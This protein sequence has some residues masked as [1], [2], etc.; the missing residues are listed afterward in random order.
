[1]RWA[2]LNRLLGTKNRFHQPG[3]LTQMV[4]TWRWRV[5]RATTRFLGVKQ[6]ESFVSQSGY[7][8]GLVLFLISVLTLTG[9]LASAAFVNAAPPAAV[10]ISASFSFNQRGLGIRRDGKLSSEA[11]SN[12]KTQLR[13]FRDV[14]TIEG[15]NRSWAA[16]IHV[17]RQQ[18]SLDGGLVMKTIPGPIPSQYWF[19]CRARGN[20]LLAWRAGGVDRACSEGLKLM[21]RWRQ[22]KSLDSSAK[23][24]VLIA[25]AEEEEFTISPTSQATLLRTEDNGSG[26]IIKTLA[27][28]FRVV[29]ANFPQGQTI[30]KGQQYAYPQDQV[31]PFNADAALQSPEVQDFLKDQNWANPNIPKPL[32]NAIKSQ[33]QS[34]RSPGLSGASKP[35]EVDSRVLKATIYLNSPETILRLAYS[36][37]PQDFSSF[38]RSN[39][40]AIVASGTFAFGKDWQMISEGRPLAGTFRFSTGT[41]LGIRA[42]NQPEM[43]TLKKEGMPNWD[44]YWFGL[45]AGPRLLK[46]GQVLPWQ[47][48]EEGFADPKVTNPDTPLGRAAIG[49]SAD[50]TRLYYVLF[51]QNISLRGAAE[52][53]KRI[54]CTEAMNL[55]GGGTRSFA[56]NGK[57]LIAGGRP[58]NHTLVVHDVNRPASAAVKQAWLAFRGA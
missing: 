43:I 53:M 54:G 44:A 4:Q 55:E 25:Q 36:G 58:Q 31:T 19:S 23:A 9:I 49:F 50:R 7:R 51:N 47:P 48:E 42:G 8:Q 28:G 32:S 3:C 57:I 39:N 21:G 45:A 13:A 1:M 46:A 40:A 6:L 29:S 30:S 16:L 37:A 35:V 15:D 26:V 38:V 34:Y 12:G 52:Y 24:G 22:L 41:V 10:L 27:G 14:M 17:S 20:F 2:L 18:P 33:L 56:H 5:V 11:I